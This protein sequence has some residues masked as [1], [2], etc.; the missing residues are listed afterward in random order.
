M[1]IARFSYCLF[2]LS[3]WLVQGCAGSHRDPENQSAT[4]PEKEVLCFI[5]HRFN[6]SRYPT[7]NTPARDFETH[8]AYLTQQGF[9]FYTFTDAVK[10]LQSDEAPKK[11]AVITIDDGYLSFFNHGLP[12]LKKYHAPATLFIN[13]KTVGSGDFMTWAD[14]KTCMDNQLEIGNHTHSHDYF[15]NK[16][17]G[18][19]YQNF[20][21]E[22]TLSQS[23]IEK[24]LAVK[25]TAFSYPYGE[26]DTRMK[27]I[28]KEAGF[29]AAAA[30]NSGVMYS[31]GDFFQFPRF[32]MSEAYS[33]KS[34][35]IE[36]ANMHAMPLTAI[37]P[38]NTA[39]PANK[40]PTLTLTLNPEKLQLKRLQCFVQGGTCRFTVVDKNKGIV[41]IQATQP[42]AKRR[43]TLYTITIPDK[44]GKWHWYSHL[45]IN[46]KMK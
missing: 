43:R 32:P 21:D 24:H 9:T 12:L 16:P 3:T 23:L 2:F 46:P 41:S 5:Y 27:T 37:D 20:R 7:T 35:F 11:I 1:S 30:Q 22:I 15:L 39:L 13:T 6:D 42:L 31:R 36:K 8:L 17:E 33:E 18:T 19:R 34:K 14:L 28:V 38:D 10:Y 4:Q 40:Q 25:S 29:I 44:D 45:W 26:F